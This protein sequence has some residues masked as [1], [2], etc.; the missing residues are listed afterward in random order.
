[1]SMKDKNVENVIHSLLEGFGEGPALIEK[2]RTRVEHGF[3][4]Y[5]VTTER[6]DLT[7]EQW[8]M[9]AIE[10]CMDACVYI[11]K[12]RA[13]SVT[14]IEDNTFALLLAG[15]L[16]ILVSLWKVTFPGDFR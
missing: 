5:G 9:H 11:E 1:M 15:Q 2:F 4:K 13:E 7:R 6:E 14:S 3:R 16:Q 8:S 10:E 12:R